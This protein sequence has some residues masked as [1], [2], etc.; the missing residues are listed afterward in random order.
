MISALVY[1]YI[2]FKLLFHMLD[3]CYFILQC[4][5]KSY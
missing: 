1:V 3:F 2:D 5:N 4:I